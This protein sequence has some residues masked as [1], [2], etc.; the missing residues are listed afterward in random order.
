M[1]PCRGHRRKKTLRSNE[2]RVFYLAKSSQ[3]HLRKA[4]TNKKTS[5]ASMTEVFFLKI[6]LSGETQLIL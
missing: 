3:V 4:E 5:C 2:R 1:G 6:E